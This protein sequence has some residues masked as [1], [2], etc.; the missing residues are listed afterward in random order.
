MTTERA[1][2]RC[3]IGT[4]CGHNGP[5]EI[6]ITSPNLFAC[7]SCVAHASGQTAQKV[8]GHLDTNKHYIRLHRA[9]STHH[10]CHHLLDPDQI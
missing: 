7:T 2:N 9:S 6:H 10:R 8:Q 1:R 4:Q 3:Q 5:V